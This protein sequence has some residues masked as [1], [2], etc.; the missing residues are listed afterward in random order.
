MDQQSLSNAKNLDHLL[1]TKENELK[2]I[3]VLKI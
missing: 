2:E 3:Q 1:E